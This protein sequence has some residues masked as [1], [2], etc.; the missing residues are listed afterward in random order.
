M[1]L[2]AIGDIHGCADELDDLLTRLPLQSGSTLVFLGDYID[3]GP[4]S[5]QV[6][7]RVLDLRRH[8]EVIALRGN[9]EQMLLEFLEGESDQLVARFVLNG[10]SSTL[11][12]YAD[13]SG[14]YG[15]P[16]SHEEFFRSL[17]Y[18]Y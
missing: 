17:P 13:P 11:A 10:G 1:P 9:H 2:Y 14:H 6:I 18:T 7:E 5:R 12:S 3:R 15:I 4:K 16:P 8:F